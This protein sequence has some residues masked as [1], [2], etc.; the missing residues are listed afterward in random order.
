MGM[1]F[2]PVFA[3]FSALLSIVAWA[4]RFIDEYSRYQEIAFLSTGSSDLLGT[5]Y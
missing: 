5:L 3:T 2:F 1:K 4:Y